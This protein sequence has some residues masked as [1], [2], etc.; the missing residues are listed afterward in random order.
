LIENDTFDGL[1]FFST[2][3]LNHVCKKKRLQIIISCVIVKRSKQ[4][5]QERNGGEKKTAVCT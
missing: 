4:V 5:R 1:I 2:N 3:I